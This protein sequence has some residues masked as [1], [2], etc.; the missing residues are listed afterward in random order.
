MSNIAQAELMFDSVTDQVRKVLFLA[1]EKRDINVSE[2]NFEIIEV[3]DVIKDLHQTLIK[4]YNAFELCCALKPIMGLNL[5]NE[6]KADKVCYADTDLYFYSSVNA[7]FD[8]MQGDFLLTPHF[9]SSPK[10]YEKISELD[11][12]N[13]GLYN[14][15]FYLFK[16]NDNTRKILEWWQNKTIEK[17]YNHSESGMFVDQIWLNYLPIY[18]DKIEVNKQLNLN[19]AYW[20]LHERNVQVEND[21]A[22]VNGEALIC[23]HF[24]GFRLTRPDLVSIHQEKYSFDNHKNLVPLFKAYYQKWTNSKH[25]KYND[26]TYSYEDSG[27]KDK[28]GKRIKD[29]ARKIFRNENPLR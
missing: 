3:R 28:V 27:L 16:S 10:D 8:S 4:K 9:V 23:Y 19:V 25:S 29:K 5:L 2:F 22:S 13:T 14:G 6:G 12:N 1:D 11:V 7:I 26:Y 20:N 24:S 21:K 17:G 15:G 18:F